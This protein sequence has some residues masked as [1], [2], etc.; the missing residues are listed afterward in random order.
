MELRCSRCGATVLRY[1]GQKTFQRPMALAFAGLLALLL[2]NTSP[3]LTF[4]V[5]GRIQKGF[6]LTGIGELLRQ[7]YWPIALLVFI[8]AILAPAAYLGSVAYVSAACSLR[9]NLANARRMLRLAELAEPWNLIPV[10]S[11]ATVVSVVK[12]RMIG[13]VTWNFGARWVLAVA[14]LTLFVQQLFDRRMV[15]RRLEAMASRRAGA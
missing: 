6:I 1:V 10:Y 4:D 14:L 15:A 9:L 13:G 5:A 7:G 3:V 2:A 12:L 8:A 11:I